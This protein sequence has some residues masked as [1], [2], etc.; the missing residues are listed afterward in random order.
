MH[1]T[2][3][4]SPKLLQYG[5]LTTFSILTVHYLN[6]VC[7]HF[8]GVSVPGSTQADIV[9]NSTYRANPPP[10]E[11]GAP[12][13]SP[14]VWATSVYVSRVGTEGPADQN[15]SLVF[16]PAV[17]VTSLYVSL[18][19]T[20]GPTDQNWSLVVKRFHV[21]HEVEHLEFVWECWS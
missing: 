18:V 4:K 21:Y 3:K 13:S 6:Y 20:V 12:V 7:S 10:A 17:W 16:S 11:T 8:V 19:G 9:R 15:W 2:L 5:C 1:C 14:A